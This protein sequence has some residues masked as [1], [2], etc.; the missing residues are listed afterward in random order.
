[1]CPR[2]EAEGASTSLYV[3]RVREYGKVCQF[4]GI[5]LFSSLPFTMIPDVRLLGSIIFPFSSILARVAGDTCHGCNFR[6]RRS[7]SAE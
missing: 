1:M 7:Q 3:L 6:Q 2:N 5:F 4:K